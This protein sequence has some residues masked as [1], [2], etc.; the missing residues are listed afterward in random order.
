[1][2]PSDRWP[3]PNEPPPGL[4]SPVFMGPITLP[5]IPRKRRWG[6]LF[7]WTLIAFAGGVAAGPTLTEQALALVTRAYSML[8]RSPPQ[9]A[10]KVEPVAPTLPRAPAAPSIEP[11]PEST[12]GAEEVAEAPAAAADSVAPK[13]AKP[14]EPAKPAGA[15]VPQP[16]A[17]AEVAAGPGRAENA[18]AKVPVARSLHAKSEA[19]TPSAKAAPTATTAKPPAS[20]PEVAPY[21]DPFADDAERTPAPKSGISGR[22]SRPSF[23]EPAPTAKSE[24]AARPAASGSQDSLDNLMADVVTTKKAKDKPREGKSLDAL[25]ND[26][27]KGGSEPAPKREAPAPLAPLSQ[28]DI[29]RVMA[30][31]KTRAKECARQLSP[32]G[33]VELTLVVA[34]DGNVTGGV[35]GKLANT[36]VAACVEKAA[37]AA[38]FPRSAG[39]RFDYRIDVR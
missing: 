13:A 30:G 25:L 6:W 16:A 32:K 35:V 12:P 22:K 36:P 2:V 4:G 23:D 19:R 18:G 20:A 8:G 34:K 27:Q 33:I 1:M 11:L 37:R 39:L 17:R 26:V 15:A 5:D 14:A 28:A 21:H 29:A 9:F 24:P 10:Q 31:V 7:L 38:S 3:V